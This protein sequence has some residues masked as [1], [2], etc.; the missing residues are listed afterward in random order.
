MNLL[1]KRVSA[2]A[3]YLRSFLKRVLRNRTRAICIICAAVMLFSVMPISVSSAAEPER[4]LPERRSRCKNQAE[5]NDARK[6]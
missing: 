2:A 6:R 3:L 5:R 1:Q 4:E